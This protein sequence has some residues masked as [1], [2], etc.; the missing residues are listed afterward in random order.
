MSA[1]GTVGAALGGAAALLRDAT[2]SPQLDAELLLAYVLKR[3]REELIA[4]REEALLSHA[5]HA[6]ASLIRRRAEGVPLP[7]LTGVIEFY[8]RPFAVTPAVLIP[9]TET[10]AVAEEALRLLDTSAV[11]HPVVAD[12][13]TGSGVLAVTIAAEAPRARVVATDRSPA[14]LAVAR[15]NARRHRI[16]RRITF[17]ESDLLTEIPQELAPHCIVANLPY[18][19]ADE[20]KR[21]GETLDTRGLTFEPPKALDGGPDGLFVIRRFFAQLRRL[22]P[23]RALLTSLILEYSPTQRR[24]ILELAHD[25][26]PTFRPRE[27]S[28]FVTSWT[29]TEQRRSGGLSP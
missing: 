18:L 13:G 15:R 16:L 4:H 24:R 23:I 19:P 20:L 29:R 12:I 8:G 3:R 7:Y 5:A 9:R 2:R 22:E 17:I 11:L 28:P 26:L 6:F 25:A 14:A 10:E 1:E 21:A 27:F